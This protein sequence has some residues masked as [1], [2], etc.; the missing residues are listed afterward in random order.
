MLHCKVTVNAILRV[1]EG[2]PGHSI[3]Q[4]DM[5]GD[6][7]PDCEEARKHTLSLAPPPSPRVYSSGKAAPT[8]G[9]RLGSSGST[10]YQVLGEPLPALAHIFKERR[11]C[12]CGCHVI[13]E[14]PAAP[15]G[16]VGGWAPQ[17]RTRHDPRGDRAHHRAAS[18]K[19]RTTKVRRYR[20]AYAARPG[21]AYAFLPCVIK[22]TNDQK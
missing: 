6:E 21:V 3:L 10:W 15:A 20:E 19:Q 16:G 8:S 11:V 18:I 12:A 1:P 14:A 4:H 17:R 7:E 9:T 22:P 2:A 5:P 13:D